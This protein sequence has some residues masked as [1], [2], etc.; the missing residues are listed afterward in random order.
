[1]GP[2]DSADVGAASSGRRADRVPWL[3]RPAYWRELRATFFFAVTLAVIEGGA[4]SI[5]VK[6][7]FA[8]VAPQARL[9]LVVAILAA[10][11]EMA[12]IVSFVW[13]SL[14]HGRRKIPLINTLQAAVI[15]CVAACGLAPRT[16]EGLY[17]LAALV[18][19]AR[20][21]WSG[22]IT[23]RPTVWRANYPRQDRARIVGRFSIMQMLAVAM[24]GMTLG[25]VLDRDSG[26]FRWLL[27]AAAAVGMI[28]VIDTSRIAVR[29]QWKLLREER[30]APSSVRAWL[31]PLEV[32]RVL[33]TD[34]R[35]AQFMLCMMLLGTGNLMLT[36][37]LAVVLT[38]QFAMGYRDGIMILSSIPALV[39]PL[40]IPL[41]ARL[42]DRAH[43]V[44]F[45]SI[46]SWVFVVSTAVM[47]M[48]VAAHSTAL[49]YVGSFIQAIA[50]GGGAL[51]WNLGHTDF[52]PVQRTSQYMA[53]H[54]TLNGVRGLLSPL[55]SIGVYQALIGA[56]V[57]ADLAASFVI[58]VCVCLC[59]SGGVGFI[60]LRRSMGDALKTARRTG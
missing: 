1:M 18:L 55:L 12:N 38:D 24:I 49:L 32:V 19:L 35:F 57:A 21:A 2:A 17:L 3:S 45:R 44:R 33:R 8:D 47:L 26:S 11:P 59:I 41:W 34:R 6:K 9:N 27:P 43:V 10:A 28:A 36:P 23:I 31:G 54:L 46:H 13:S 5:V 58:A 40:S 20:I 30:A 53:T 22:I 56:G 39:M 42:L 7:T 15:V 14:S 60:M 50:L 4:I 37:V 16:Q 48:A 52:A 25:S 29:S 51:A